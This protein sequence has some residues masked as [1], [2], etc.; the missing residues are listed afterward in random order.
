VDFTVILGE[1]NL[2]FKEKFYPFK[3][4]KTYDFISQADL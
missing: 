4:I 2:D 1:Q 3:N